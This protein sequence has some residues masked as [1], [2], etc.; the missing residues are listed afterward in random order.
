MYH[1]ACIDKWFE[2]KTKCPNCRWNILVNEEEVRMNDNM[3]NFIEL[4]G[5][6]SDSSGSL[7]SEEDVEEE[8]QLPLNNYILDIIYA[9]VRRRRE[10]ILKSYTTNTE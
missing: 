5:S 3:L 9:N 7:S 6:S 2:E 10:L 1:K 4:E 8:D